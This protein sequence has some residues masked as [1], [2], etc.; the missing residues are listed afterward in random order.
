MVAVTVVLGAG[1]VAAWIGVAAFLRLPTPLDRL[2]VVT[3]VNVAVGAAVTAAAVLTDGVS[4]RSLKVA[5]LW[6]LTLIFGALL[7]HVTAR[8]I[9]FRDGERR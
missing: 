9:F 1:L 7:S 3:F 5:L 4:T 2:H 8:A 6:G